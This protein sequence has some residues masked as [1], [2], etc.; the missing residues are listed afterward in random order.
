MQ[1]QSKTLTKRFSGQTGEPS[2]MW[3]FVILE[4]SRK[5]EIW[6]HNL[7]LLLFAPSVGTEKSKQ[8]LR[9][10]VNFIMTAKDVILFWKQSWGTAAFSALMLILI[11]LAHRFNYKKLAVIE[12]DKKLVKTVIIWRKALMF[13]HPKNYILL[14]ILNF[15]YGTDF[16]L[17]V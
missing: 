3:F 16:A 1:A 13:Y 2:F 9:I 7:S 5:I 17:Y 10:G 14:K 11:H 8:C 4:Y 12:S 6:N 15:N